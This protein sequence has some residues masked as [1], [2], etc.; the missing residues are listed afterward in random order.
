VGAAVRRTKAKNWLDSGPRRAILPRVRLH[1]LAKAR[2]SVCPEID[3][4]R[5]LLPRRVIAAAERRA[6]AIGVGAERVLICADAITEEAYVTAL[7][8]SLGTSYERFDGRSRADCPLD[9]DGLIQAA[10]AGLLPLRHG[11]DLVWI[12]APRGL[13]ARRLADPHQ[14]RPEWLRSFR[15]TS[16]DRL[17][18]FVAQHTQ[19]AL[20]RRAAESLRLRWPFYSNAPPAHGRR[21]ITAIALSTLAFAFFALAPV[22]MIEALSGLLCAL[23]LAA[24]MLRLLSACFMSD[25]SK[26]PVHIDDA[27]LPIYTIICA[28]YREA[29]VVGDLVAA[30]LEADDHETRGALARFNLGLPFEI[31]TAPPVGPRTKPKALNVALP[32]A[33]G[34]YTVIYD[35]EDVPEPDQ[36]RRALDAFRGG[37]N[38]LACVQASLTIDNPADHWLARMFTANYAP[39]SSTPSSRG[40]RRCI[41][42]FRWA[43]RPII[44]A[45]RCCARSAAGIPTMSPKTPTSASD[46]VASVIE[47]RLCHP[48]PMRKRRRALS[49]GSRNAHAGIRAG[50][51]PG[52]CTC[53]APAGY[54]GNWAW[55]APS[56]FRFSSPPMC[57]RP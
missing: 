48:R 2:P 3:C 10:A 26:R 57:S 29:P 16:A 5:H 54:C 36:L 47:R 25:A 55:P 21:G 12:I 37:G 38:R 39:A 11:R 17:R 7:A 6:G 9:D 51:K 15:L 45:R 22:A 52:W 18:H 42:R 33:R 35:A 32:F 4:V 49:R 44:S 53:A 43:A 31:I 1:A 27:K 28:L 41:C 13:T 14:S 20:G 46:S 8:N 56:H 30:I 24:A 23:F 19:R 40:S 34:L 50:C